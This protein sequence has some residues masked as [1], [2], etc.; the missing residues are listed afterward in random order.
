MKSLPGSHI[1]EAVMN[2]NSGFDTVWRTAKVCDGG[3]CIEIGAQDKIIMIRDSADREG[4]R[5]ALSHQ[6]WRNFVV[7]VKDGL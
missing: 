4:G 2:N 6:Q 1:Y 3:Q 5:I 7:A